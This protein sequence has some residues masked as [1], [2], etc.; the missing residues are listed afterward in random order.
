MRRKGAKAAHVHVSAS[1]F[2]PLSR[3][4]RRPQRMRVAV[5]ADET[6]PP[7]APAWI[8]AHMVQSVFAN[9]APY[10]TVLGVLE[11][12]AR[13]D[14]DDPND[15]PRALP[16]TRETPI[17]AGQVR[18][19][20]GAGLRQGHCG[21]AAAEGPGP[22]A[23]C[24]PLQ[25]CDAATLTSA[26][27]LA[28]T[29]GGPE[30]DALDEYLLEPIRWA[31]A[32]AVALDWCRGWESRPPSIPLW[33]QPPP[34]CLSLCP[35]S[36]VSPPPPT[37][38]KL[39]NLSFYNEPESCDNCTNCERCLGRQLL[40]ALCKGA[41]PSRRTTACITAI[42]AA[43]SPPLPASPCA[44]AHFNSIS[45]QIPPATGPR[46]PSIVEAILAN[47]ALPPNTNFGYNTIPLK[48]GQVVQLVI[49]NYDTGQLVGCTGG[50]LQGEEAQG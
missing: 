34:P 42:E 13:W 41:Q 24:T 32:G 7:G 12:G 44:G 50:G 35:C 29:M 5:C 45:M 20:A 6:H 30:P 19:G 48:A 8:R 47:H 3:P 25:P 1:H 2:P 27:V 11:Y 40:V 37:D 49:N 10:P 43:H 16:T 38:I 36:Q 39:L 18:A 9:P 4:L 17:P 26:L 46:V 33:P 31:A 28:Q 14:T 15:R 22:A 21:R 23:S